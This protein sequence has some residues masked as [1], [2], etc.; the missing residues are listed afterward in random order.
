VS[1]EPNIKVLCTS[2]VHRCM[3][4]TG[5][6]FI[7]FGVLFIIFYAGSFW[8]ACDGNWLGIPL[9]LVAALVA[10]FV[11][12][13]LESP[14][15]CRVLAFIWKGSP[16]V[17]YRKWLTLG[18]GWL[19]FGTRFVRLDAVEEL[20]FSMHGNVFIDE[21]AGNIFGGLLLASRA[22]C[23]QQPPRPDVVLKLPFGVAGPAEQKLL[24]EQIKE[25]RPDVIIH[26]RLR[27]QLELRRLP[28]QTALQFPSVVII[29]LALLDL[30]AAS[31]VYLETLKQYYLAHQL[32][33][34]GKSAEAEEHLRQADQLRTHHLPVSFVQPAIFARG[35]S[36]AGLERE[37]S[38]VLE[39]L[40]RK[41][42]A[43]AA[44]IAACNLDPD[45]F[46]LHLYLARL[47]AANGQ[48]RKAAAEIADAVYKHR[49][50][51]LTR[52]YM[53]AVLQD[54]SPAQLSPF[55]QRYMDNYQV[56]VFA[57]EPRWPPG[58]NCSLIEDFY[59]D[60]LR[61]IL[62][63]LLAPRPAVPTLDRKLPVPAREP[64][65]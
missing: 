34:A 53:L 51:L 44:A 1:E 22:V 25:R 15:A 54:F 26:D 61:F 12:E 23:G 52:L 56:V 38:E 36:A 11:L 43:L 47:F 55:Y 49:D 35:P 46:R 9:V 18:D 39:A 24:V 40:G 29:S 14:T 42:E 60:D 5:F 7:T 32:A 10:H 37:R 59:S 28:F 62:D 64:A 4:L 6:T 3:V 27:R 20:G 31:F 17:V 58:H 57:D 50:S 21:L 13:A 65:K 33:L 2:P 16:P 19:R 45:S 63:R 41:H 30:G 8:F 48:P